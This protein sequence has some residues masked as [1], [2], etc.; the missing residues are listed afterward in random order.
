MLNKNINNGVLPWG[1]IKLPLR[2]LRLRESNVL[3]LF[4][5]AEEQWRREMLDKNLTASKPSDFLE[6][7]PCTEAISEVSP[8]WVTQVCLRHLTPFTGYCLF[9]QGQVQVNA[10]P[11]CEEPWREFSE[12]FL[13]CFDDP[14]ISVL[15]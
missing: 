3:R 10:V 15:S 4:L 11:R 2:S 5:L 14:G 13:I 6:T 9:H 12:L 8:G 7:N 1:A